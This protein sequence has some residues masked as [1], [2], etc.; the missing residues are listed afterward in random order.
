MTTN[1]T[2]ALYIQQDLFQNFIEIRGHKGIQFGCF[3]LS[4]YQ[5]RRQKI[6]RKFDVVLTVHRR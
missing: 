1:H 6:I 5:G 2:S 3:S 4:D